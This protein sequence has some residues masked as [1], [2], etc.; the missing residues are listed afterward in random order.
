M[1][2]LKYII[3]DT[4][5]F[6]LPVIFPST[7]DHRTMFENVAVG[8]FGNSTIYSAGFYAHGECYGNS[9]TLRVAMKDG[10]SIIISNF[11]SHQGVKHDIFKLFDDKGITHD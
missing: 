8:L 9:V 1:T 3:Y 11:A 2:Y 7:I 4:G 6:L 5:T 10:D